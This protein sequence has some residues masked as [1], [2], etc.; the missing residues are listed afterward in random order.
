[1]VNQEISQIWGEIADALE[2]KDENRFRVLAYRRG[3]EALADLNEDVTVLLAE[4]RLTEV[5]GIGKGLA[6]DIAEYLAHHR[7]AAHE[8]AM[9][10]IPPRL[11]SLLK[12]SGLGPKR[13]ARLH[14]ELGVSDAWSLQDAIQSGRLAALSGFG[15]KTAENLGR[16]LERVTQTQERIPMAEA[17]LLTRSVL[18]HLGKKVDVAHATFAGSFRR[19]RESCGDL[20]LLVPS[21]KGAT[22]VQAFTELPGVERVLAAGDTRG[23][24]LI[25]GRQVDLRVVPPASFGAALC[26]FTGSKDHNVRLREIAKKQ[27]L[28]INEYGVFRED[29]CLGGLTEADVYAAIELPWIPPEIRE[30]RGE[31]EAAREGKLPDLVERTDVRGDF[32]L[33]T[34]WGDGREDV[35]AMVKKAADLG[36][37]VVAIVD[38]ALSNVYPKGLT[39]EEWRKQKRAVGAARRAVPG[40]T[41]LHGLEVDIELDGAIVWPAD[42]L[43]EIEWIAA[44]IHAGFED[45]VTERTLAAMENPHVD[46]IVHPT[47][48]I[49]LRREGYTGLELDRVFEKAKATGTALEMNASPERLD[50]PAEA[51]RRAAEKGVR[52]LFGTDARSPEEMENI[53]VG[54]RT[55]RRGW[56]SRDQGRTELPV[57]WKALSRGA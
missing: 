57:K 51:A 36:H 17:L 44:G 37:R 39:P 9:E 3:A 33:H 35:T 40:V 41:V 13:L 14:A 52:L 22:V 12:V 11:L 4:K 56:I 49:V 23:S 45:R 10:G 8:R 15:A 21:K 32:H 50:L 7:M 38:H 1:M 16:A 29:V 43:A 54:V 26:Y 6:Q 46:C 25:A 34:S 48:R 18:E 55:A 2:F 20:D 27:G 47:G 19:G 24:V 31:I 28:K 42:A 53:D 30:D 5:P